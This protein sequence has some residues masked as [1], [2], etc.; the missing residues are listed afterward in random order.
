MYIYIRMYSTYIYIYISIIDYH[1]VDI[2]NLPKDLQ[3]IQKIRAAPR[4]AVPAVVR[5]SDAP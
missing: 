3:E 5:C 2:S 1:S 4:S